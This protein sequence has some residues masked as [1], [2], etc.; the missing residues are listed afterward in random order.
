[1]G[2]GKSNDAMTPLVF[3]LLRA[4]TPPRIKTT[5]IDERIE[6]LEMVDTDLVAISVETFTARRAYEIAALYRAR[7][8]PVVMGGQHPTLLPKEA[9]QHCDSVVIGDAEGQWERLIED[10][11]NGVLKPVYNDGYR[12]Q[13]HDGVRFDRSIFEGK[14]YLPIHLV[15]VGSGCRYACEFCSI[16]AF[17]KESRAQRPAAEVAAE[18]ATLSSGRLIFFVDDNL[19]W[20]REKFVELM[21]A[22][23]P[24]KRMWSCQISI[25]V[26]RDDGLLDLMREAGCRLV[27]MGLESLNRDNLRK[28]HKNW[29]HVAGSYEEVVEKLHRRGIM[30]YGTFVF[31][32]DEDMHSD[33]LA[34][35]EF[36]RKN[37]FTIA[38]FNPLTPYPGTDLYKRLEEEGGLLRAKWW[39]DTD[40]KYGD[41]VIRP[42]NMTPEELTEGPMAAREIF[43]SWPSILRR[44][45]IGL[46]RWRRPK[47]VGLLL[48]SNLVS[49]R[50]ISR[51]QAK[52][53]TNAGAS[54]S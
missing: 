26:A 12:P 23:I 31:G 36:A 44:A 30:I 38:N 43:Y 14:S 3:A 2:E 16:H 9:G 54:V 21:K 45:A 50:E 41:P 28:M 52:P 8:V 34:T 15:Q 5:L 19:L 37:A 25:D 46:A 11:E 53:L 13:R 49:R 40:F 32:Y 33:F 24:L 42:R 7:G 29:N 20:Q 51:K 22:L 4:A 6:P 47:S 10:A 27:L 18:I 48:F 39:T 17:Y 1:L 35:A